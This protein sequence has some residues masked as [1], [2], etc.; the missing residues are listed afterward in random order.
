M[1]SGQK[2][3]S[4]G[5]DTKNIDTKVRPQDDFYH[6]ANGTW[7]KK[8]KIP[9]E[10]A[11]V[12]SFYDLRLETEKQLKVIM[13]RVLVKKNH[14]KGTPEQLL[15]DY[16]RSAADMK[17]RNALG[18]KPLAEYREKIDAISSYETLVST[19]A[20]LHK[21]GVSGVWGS[22]MDQDF[23]DSTTYRMFLWQGG[24]SLP[25]RDYY[26]LDAPE[27]KRV[28][29]AY[30]VH[31]EKL[32]KLA[33]FKKQDIS[34][35]QEIVLHIE[36]RLAKAS[37]KKEDSR[38]PEKV[39]HKQTPDAFWKKYFE[40]LGIKNISTVIVGQP[41]FFKEVAKMLKEVA[42]DDWKTYLEWHLINDF[43]GTL[44]EAFVKE[45][46]RFYSQVMYG[47]KKM[48]P[49]W[50]RALSAAGGALGEPLG[51]IYIKEYFPESAKKK[52]DTLVTDLFAVYE[53]RIRELDWMSPE[54]KKKAVAKLRV[55]KRKIAYPTKWDAYK[56]V[57]ISPTDYFGNMRQIH[58]HDR[59][60]MLRKLKKPVDR[61][62]W[63]TTPQV[64]NAFYNP[65]LNDI[66]FPAAILQ[67]PFF[68]PNADDALNYA[69][70][71]SVIG[72]EMT[73]GFDDSGAKFNGDGNMKD[74]W[75]PKDKKSFEQKG[76]MIVDQ[77]NEYTVVD[78]IKL[79]GQHTLGENI[80]DFGGLV[81]AYDAYQ[82]HLAKT[83]R[84][85]IDGLSPEQRF[86]LAFAQMERS[87]SRP[88]V[89]KVR[90]LT[91]P[92]ANAQFRV[93]AP[94]S[95]FEPFYETFN[96]KKGDKLYREPKDRAKIW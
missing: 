4:W 64:V 48:K 45:N 17:R 63:I 52:I 93:N 53:G 67:W 49:M 10:E 58:E 14:K 32:L 82:K 34:R 27:Q 44:S 80:A 16:Y 56:D 35:A 95:N 6:Y 90:A 51:K 12:G 15:S 66:N 50:R 42:L 23:K 59:K 46:F 7:I 71:G 9:P 3:A 78:D 24:L 13:D 36:T 88:E 74:W 57:S 33:G 85:D 92:H 29:E 5:F 84:K 62:E 54:T 61:T 37:M 21:E 86:F 25:D 70:I 55:M 26:L 18:I 75:T 19:I 30:V 65:G 22:F 43:A 77:A 69:G 72:H 20:Y 39:Y 1:K 38:D 91:D 83:G 28:R 11:Q 94:F 8:A 60:K 76:K 41:D 47:T 68:D 31:I 96:V 87:V 2:K 40:R 79:N 81:I 73:H 89:V